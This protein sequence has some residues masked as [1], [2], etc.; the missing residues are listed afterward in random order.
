MYVLV[1]INLH[2]ETT[3]SQSLVTVVAETRVSAPS[4]RVTSSSTK[5]QPEIVE[6]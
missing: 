5:V 3:M 2:A 6:E 1:E 4:R